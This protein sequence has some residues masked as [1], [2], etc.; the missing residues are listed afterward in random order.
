MQ[1]FLNKNHGRHF[2][3]IISRLILNVR[4]FTIYRYGTQEIYNYCFWFTL[5]HI[6]PSVVIHI[7]TR[8]APVNRHVTRQPINRRSTHMAHAVQPANQAIIDNSSNIT[9]VNSQSSVY[10][11]L[12]LQSRNLPI[13]SL[14]AKSIDSRQRIINQQLNTKFRKRL[15]GLNL[16]Q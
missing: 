6:C 9:Y 8:S 7:Y 14:I 16:W 1:S 5:A 15:I 11:W 10:T 12:K 13:C 3:K 4:I 2:K